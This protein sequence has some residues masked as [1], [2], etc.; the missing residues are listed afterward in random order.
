M[1]KMVFKFYE[2]DPSPGQPTIRGQYSIFLELKCFR[3]LFFSLITSS[4][5]TKKCSLFFTPDILKLH[6]R[7]ISTSI[8]QT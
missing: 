2:M 4:V 5:L 3:K 6:S 7:A 8:L 1:P